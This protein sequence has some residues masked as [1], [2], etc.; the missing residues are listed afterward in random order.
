MKTTLDARAVFNSARSRALRINEIESRIDSL[1]DLAN[2]TCGGNGPKVRSS[3]NDQSDKLISLLDENT[4]LQFEL[5][6]LK[7]E[8]GVVEQLIDCVRADI[9][10]KYADALREYYICAWTWDDVAAVHDVTKRTVMTWRDV[11]MDWIDSTILK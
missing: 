2:A 5:F 9:S 1:C 10:D 11:A 7:C 4:R 6:E 3:A 8:Q